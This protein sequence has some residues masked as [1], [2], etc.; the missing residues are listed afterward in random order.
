[1]SYY[2]YAK[3]IAAQARAADDAAIRVR[4]E[5]KARQAAKR[6]E[7]QQQYEEVSAWQSAQFKA[8]RDLGDVVRETQDKLDALAAIVA[9][10]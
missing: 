5:A 4:N 7:L 2:L 3:K 8:G 6:R 10:A 9:A 1:M